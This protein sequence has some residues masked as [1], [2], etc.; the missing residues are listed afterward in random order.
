MESLNGRV[1]LGVLLIIVGA[2]FLALNQFPEL[3]RAG[4]WW[5]MFV[6]LPGMAL[7]SAGVLGRAQGSALR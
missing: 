6:I 5:P 2:F 7:L 3:F 4:E 1:L